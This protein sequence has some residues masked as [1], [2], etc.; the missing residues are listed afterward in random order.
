[1]ERA[2]AAPLGLDSFPRD[3]YCTSVRDRALFAPGAMSACGVRAAL[4]CLAFLFSAPSFAADIQ[5]ENLTSSL[6]A[7]AERG[8]SRT[9]K[10]L[11]GLGASLKDVDKSGN[12]VV[13]MAA[14]GGEYV[15]MKEFLSSGVSPNV[16]G[17]SGLTP[18]A[19][20]AMRGEEMAVKNLL[21]WGADPN[22]PSSTN[23]TPLHLAAQFGRNGIVKT[24]LE[25]NSRVDKQNDAGETPLMVAIR[26]GNREGFEL[27]LKQRPNMMLRNKENHDLLFIAMIENQ[28]DMALRLLE[29]GAP[30]RLQIGSYT[31]LHWAR[32][33]HQPRLVDMLEKLGP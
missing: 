1:M 11:T 25:A 7:A 15:L 24:L 30:F 13:L 23:D 27:L 10:L 9:I 31:P 6:L 29:S 19:V 26:K 8:D 14:L 21:A 17:N 28:E 3:S 5:P 16:R 20:A 4:F 18:L 12:N 2:V 33:M 32:A 22:L